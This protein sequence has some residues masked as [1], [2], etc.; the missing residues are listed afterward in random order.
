[1]PPQWPSGIDPTSTCC[2]RLS[3]RLS[4]GRPLCCLLHC[5]RLRPSSPSTNGPACYS[6]IAKV[7]PKVQFVIA[8]LVL[9]YFGRLTC[10]AALQRMP[11]VAS[12][13][14][15][16]SFV[17][18]GGMPAPLGGV[19]AS[20]DPVQEQG[21]AMPARH[22]AGP[23]A[24][25]SASPG[26]VAFTA[27]CWK[28]LQSLFLTHVLGLL[29]CRC[30]DAM[31]LTDFDYA[32][33]R[34]ALNKL[35]ST[36]AVDLK[37]PGGLPARACASMKE[38]LYGTSSTNKIGT[39]HE[40]VTCSSQAREGLHQV[41]AAVFRAAPQTRSWRPQRKVW[42][43]VGGLRCLSEI[44]LS[45][46]A[47]RQQGLAKRVC[48]H[49]AGL[50][51]GPP[52]VPGPSEIRRAELRK[53]TVSPQRPQGR[54]AVQDG[55]SFSTAPPSKRPH[56]AGAARPRPLD[57]EAAP[58]DSACCKAHPPCINAHNVGAQVVSGKG[59]DCR[60]RG[61]MQS[62][63]LWCMP[64]QRRYNKSQ[65][66]HLTSFEVSPTSIRRHAAPHNP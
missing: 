66:G 39:C 55:A 22:M 37:F 42:Q 46:A 30:P 15:Y 18:L 45:P 17:C 6:Q 7:L 56:L 59:D 54:A 32:K 12:W 2:R 33:A 57:G 3:T 20:T 14:E 61:I 23:P 50:R 60:L 16:V 8:Q 34:A 49:A 36:P 27:L 38:L 64:P 44:H 51:T 24:S 26:F 29:H 63:H 41:A 58:V 35:Q 31:I 28:W 53:R 21:M 47:C 62:G 43:P 9:L 40:G 48:L 13:G 4:S 10:T 19:Q 5:S 52:K 25:E 1:M 11:Y 65:V